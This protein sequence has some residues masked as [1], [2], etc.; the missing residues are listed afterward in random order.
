MYRP[1]RYADVVDDYIEEINTGKNIHKGKA[2]SAYIFQMKLQYIIPDR[3]KHCTFKYSINLKQ[4]LSILIRY[5]L[6]F[7]QT[8][9]GSM[10]RSFTDPPPQQKIY[11]AYDCR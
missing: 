7:F 6:Y 10:A 3:P 4:Y 8:S 2:G 9:C 11:I 1:K 5:V